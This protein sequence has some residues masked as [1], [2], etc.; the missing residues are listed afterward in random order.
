VGDEREI[1]KHRPLAK[2]DDVCVPLLHFVEA[3][4]H[5]NVEK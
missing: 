2:C 4:K 1:L 5:K 3:Y